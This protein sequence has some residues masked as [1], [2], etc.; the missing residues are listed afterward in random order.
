MESAC[1]VFGEV[2]ETI[3]QLSWEML[4]EFVGEV[5]GSA[6]EFWRWEVIV[7]FCEE[8]LLVLQI[9]WNMYESDVLCTGSHAGAAS[10]A[11]VNSAKLRYVDIVDDERMIDDVMIAVIQGQAKPKETSDEV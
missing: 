2:G 5:K 9:V 3:V 1:D 6:A 8:E 4:L 11:A 7:V 10:A